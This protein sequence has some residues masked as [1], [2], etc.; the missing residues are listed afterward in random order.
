M[1][2]IYPEHRENQILPK[3]RLKSRLFKLF[4]AILRHFLCHMSSVT[5]IN[6]WN[7]KPGSYLGERRRSTDSI[8]P[9]LGRKPLAKHHPEYE[10]VSRKNNHPVYLQTRYVIARKKILILLGRNWLW[11]WGRVVGERL[12][13]ARITD[14]YSA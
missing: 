8:T 10:S 11:G 12:A 5:C 1:I 13:R 4:G 2:V 3:L 7:S 14:I 9:T 6:L